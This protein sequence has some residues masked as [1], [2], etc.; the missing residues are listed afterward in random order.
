MRC[1][2]CNAPV[3]EGSSTCL[4]C[5]ASLPVLDWDPWTD[6]DRVGVR[7]NSGEENF[8]RSQRRQ[9]HHEQMHSVQAAA[10][11]ASLREH[12]PG[13]ARV[14]ARPAAS[15]V[16]DSTGQ[17]PKSVNGKPWGGWEAATSDRHP[18]P[19]GSAS[20]DRKK[21]GNNKAGLL[22]VAIWLLILFL[23]SRLPG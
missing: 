17:G 13:Q 1:P 20:S 14:T 2:N 9:A 6:E 12:S 21:K 16:K 5:G 11:S 8:F 15:T 23:L 10:K 3:P 22:V 18:S 7:K 19:G 4:D